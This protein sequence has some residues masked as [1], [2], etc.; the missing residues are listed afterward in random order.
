MIVQD[1]KYEGMAY[2]KAHDEKWTGLGIAPADDEMKRIV[3][4]PTTAATLNLA[5]CAAQAARLWKTTIKIS[6][7]NALKPQK[8]HTKQL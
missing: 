1:G 6:P 7:T 4:P 5:A 2:H 8:T 3:K